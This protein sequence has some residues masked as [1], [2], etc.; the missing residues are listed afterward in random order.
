[1]SLALPD[2]LVSPPVWN[3]HSQ[4]MLSISGEPSPGSSDKSVPVSRTSYHRSVARSF[5]EVKARNEA[6]LFHP[7]KQPAC[8]EITLLIT[9][10]QVNEE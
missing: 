10:V 3:K 4:L 6:L 7:A 8:P 5:E 9:D 2:A 1:M